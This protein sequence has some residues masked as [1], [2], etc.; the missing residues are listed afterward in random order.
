[1]SEWVSSQ[2]IVYHHLLSACYIQWPIVTP[3][4]PRD[5]CQPVLDKLIT[6]GPL[7]DG[8]WVA[9]PPPQRHSVYVAMD[10]GGLRCMEL[11]PSHWAPDAANAFVTLLAPPAGTHLLPPAL[12]IV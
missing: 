8:A 7:Y 1:M 4:L 5:P 2:G 9:G 10:E 6:R 12:A 3:L 11:A